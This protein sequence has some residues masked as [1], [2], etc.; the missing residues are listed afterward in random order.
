MFNSRSKG[1]TTWGFRLVGTI[2]VILWAGALPALASL[3]IAEP[4]GPD[5]ELYNKGRSFVF[6]E[7]WPEA[8]KV[9]E[10]LGRRYPR[11]PYLDDAL[12]WTAFALFHEGRSAQAYN[13]LQTLTASYPD[14]PW[15]VDARALMVRCAEGALRSQASGSGARSKYR[16]FLYESTR[17]TNDRV[18]L[19]ALGTLLNEDP[20]NAPQLITQVGSNTGGGAVVLL[21]RFFGREKVKVSFE[22][23]SA[24]LAEGNVTIMVRGEDRGFSLTLP[25]ALDAVEG[26]GPAQFN[27]A[28]RNEMRKRIVEAQRGLVKQG[29]IKQSP[30]N[31]GD[32]SRKATV[33][34]VVDGEVHYYENGAEAVKIVVLKRAAG[35]SPANVMI[36]VERGNNIRKVE[37]DHMTSTPLGPSSRGMSADAR[38]FLIQS[39]RVIE[40]DLGSNSP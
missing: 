9:F 8:R 26:R 15:S 39:L 17:D 12:Y 23:K 34:Q 29:P 10:T 19:L 31:T 16:Q 14:T 25:E 33:V 6:E 7:S 30:P 28:V 2:L 32:Y 24:G 3:L 5:Q 38:E 18:S 35:F 22:D 20:G 40:L 1:Q 37:L 13:R 27:Q 36:F 11:S 21:D 4:S